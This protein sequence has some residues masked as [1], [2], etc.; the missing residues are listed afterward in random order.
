MIARGKEGTADIAFS[1]QVWIM[2]DAARGKSGGGAGPAVSPG[3]A[4]A[5]GRISGAPGARASCLR[6]EIVFTWF[7]AELV[8]LMLQTGR[9]GHTIFLALLMGYCSAVL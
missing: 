8:N 1:P 2:R 5:R 6:P 3:A 4:L 9:R 7:A